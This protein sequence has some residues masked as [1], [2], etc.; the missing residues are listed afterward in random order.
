MRE[1]KGYLISF[2]GLDGAGKTTQV[3]LLARWLDEN[4]AKV[5]L[6]FVAIEEQGESGKR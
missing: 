4:L 1:K 5:T 2:E 3:E 6:R